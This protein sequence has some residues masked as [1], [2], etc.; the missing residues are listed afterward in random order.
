[1]LEKETPEDK[2]KIKVNRVFVEWSIRQNAFYK[3]T[4]ELMAYFPWRYPIG[5]YPRNLP[6][7]FFRVSSYFV[8]FGYQA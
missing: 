2:T 3:G 7:L 6:S 4:S 8:K 1:M 5:W